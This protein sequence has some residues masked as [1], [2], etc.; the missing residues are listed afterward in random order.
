MA[1]HAN[2]GPVVRRPAV[3]RCGNVAGVIQRVREVRLG[4]GR[5]LVYV[6]PQGPPGWHGKLRRQEAEEV[7]GGGVIYEAQGHHSVNEPPEIDF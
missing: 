4:S 5:G 7:P 3:G 2:E 6:S 1:R